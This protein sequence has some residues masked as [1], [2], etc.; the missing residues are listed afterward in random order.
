MPS[1]LK[2]YLI[3]I[4]KVKEQ[5]PKTVVTDPLT[6]TGTLEDLATITGNI[7]MKELKKFHKTYLT[8]NC[9]SLS[10]EVQGGSDSKNMLATLEFFHPGILLLGTEQHDF[11][12]D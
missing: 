3:P 11:Y 4:T 6:T 5:F 9:G 10:H 12:C 8:Q 1:T 7:V 2:P